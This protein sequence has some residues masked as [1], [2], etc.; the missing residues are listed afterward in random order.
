MYGMEFQSGLI[1]PRSLIQRWVLKLQRIPTPPN[2]LSSKNS[3]AGVSQA[4]ITFKFQTH[5]IHVKT[6]ERNYSIF[7]FQCFHFPIV[8]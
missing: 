2:S 8:T 1:F 4:L 3:K 6:I 5:V 7:L